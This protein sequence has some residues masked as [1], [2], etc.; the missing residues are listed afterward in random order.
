MSTPGSQ[1][2]EFSS[3]DFSFAHQ[4]LQTFPVGTD[5]AVIARAQI[6]QLRQTEAFLADIESSLDALSKTR[7][8]SEG[9]EAGRRQARAWREQ[10]G[11]E[12]AEI[13]YREQLI[14]CDR[15]SQHIANAIRWNAICTDPDW[16]EVG[17]TPIAFDSVAVIQNPVLASPNFKA[18]DVPVYRVDDMHFGVQAVAGRS[19]GSGSAAGSGFVKILSGSASVRVNNRPVARNASAAQINCGPDGLGGVRGAL[20]TEEKPPTPPPAPAQ[21]IEQAPPGPRTSPRLEEL[22]RAEAALQ[23]RLV[24]VNGVDE[25][26]RF[27]DLY[28]MMDSGI[29][30][31]KGS[32]TDYLAQATRGVLKA[33]V[34][35]G[36]GAVGLGKLAV[37]ASQRQ[38]VTGMALTTVQAQIAA[39]NIR[40]GNTA[41]GT[42]SSAAGNMALSIVVPPEAQTAWKR[43]DY[44]EAGTT[45][46]IN[47]ATLGGGLRSLFKRP[48][49]ATQAADD[50]ASGAAA[51]RAADEAADAAGRSADDLAKDAAPTRPASTATQT[52]QPGV[53][54]SPT[55]KLAPGTAEHKADRWRRYQSRGGTKSYEAWSK[56]YDT[57]M[58]NYRVGLA[59]EADY[60]R[61]MGA[62][63]GT[64]KTPLTNRQVDIL[65]QSE[66]YAGQLKSGPVSLT[67]D[68]VLAI[69][70]DAELV[71]RGWLVEHILEKGAS[72]PYLDALDAAGINYHL[73]PKI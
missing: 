69:Q 50:V 42:A 8:L 60:R 62:T 11:R 17:G 37:S 33:G 26:I 27:D 20:L 24:N 21:S 58:R 57:N 10:A 70:K 32:W 41:L 44:V 19:L 63:E 54:V 23:E 61:A 25:Y 4:T 40:L 39:E 29:Q 2:I 5:P 55:R 9:E 43:G 30:G 38:T 22:K 72:K 67:R 66:G 51:G 7:R 49:T 73:G 46:G 34:A 36:E 31:T 3:P 68:N 6:E 45:T 47:L 12:R 35:V 56:Q 48:T 64:L 53:H 15:P 52:E 65:K 16:C 71:K 59:R 1:R 13:E 18:Q 28:R 14:A